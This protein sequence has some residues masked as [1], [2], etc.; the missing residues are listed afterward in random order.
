MLSIREMDQKMEERHRQ[1]LLRDELKAIRTELGLEKPQT[2]TLVSK[3]RERLA[4]KVVPE[5]ARKVIDEEMVRRYK[6]NK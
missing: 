6:N 3:F 4:K 2:E 5:H 1:M